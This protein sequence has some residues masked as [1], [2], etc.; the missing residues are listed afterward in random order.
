M[1]LSPWGHRV[2]H[3]WATNTHMIT[4]MLFLVTKQMKT[5]WTVQKMGAFKLWHTYKMEYYAVIKMFRKRFLWNGEYL[6]H[7]V[8]WV[9]HKGLSQ[10]HKYMYGEKKYTKY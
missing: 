2:R 4:L 7:S 8:K 5:V 3:D 1:G 6:W 9:M 10:L